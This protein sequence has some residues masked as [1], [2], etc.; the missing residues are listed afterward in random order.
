[1]K[2]IARRAGVSESAVSFALNDRPGVSETTRS[3]VRRVADQLGWR[4]S[5]AARALS[6]EGAATVGLVLARPASSLGIESFFL[7]LVSGIQEVLSERHLGLLF[8]VVAGAEEECAVYRRWW[9]EQRVD[10]VI[11]V[12]PRIGDPRPALLDSLGL[13]AVVVGGREVDRE[14]Q[15]PVPYPVISTVRVDDA[16]AMG[17]IVEHLAGLGH[18]RVVHVAGLAGLAHTTRRVAS[19]R[20][21]AA[22]LGMSAVRSVTTDYSEGQGAEATRLALAGPEPPTAIIYDNDVMAVAGAGVALG[23]GLSVPRDLSVVA[24]EDSALCR[25]THPRLTALDRDATAFGRR[26][27]EE[28]VGLLGGRPARDVAQPT[29]ELVVR[30]STAPPLRG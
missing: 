21:G 26:A 22:S 28:L 3:R 19:L 10:G 9:A 2:D 6:G 18:R 16:A 11:V 20:A 17:A 4:A 15:E 23:M 5:T 8:R 1:M 27:A 29:P 12:D 14:P 7:Q 24:W 25:A 30:D 13:P